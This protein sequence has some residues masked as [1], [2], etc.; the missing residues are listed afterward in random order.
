MGALIHLESVDSTNNFLKALALT[1]AAPGTAV[2]A[3]GQTAGRGR[4]E[5]GF[6]SPPG[7]GLYLS[8]LLC[9][10]A[11][12]E[13]LPQLTAWAGVAVCRALGGLG[14]D[15]GIK[16]VNDLALGGRKLGGIL[17]ELLPPRDGVC[18]VVVGVGLD[19]LQ[20]SFPAELAPIATSVL[21]E[22]GRHIP[23]PRAAEAVLRELLALET[24]FP[25]EKAGYLADY[26]RLCVTT[27]RQVSY[28]TL[29]ETRTG[30][31]RSV[32]EDFGLVVDGSGG[33]ETLRFGEVSVRPVP[34]REKG[35]SSD[36]NL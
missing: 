7:E 15:A 30:L 29:G 6:Y 26:R 3:D 12:V 31:A 13:A 17:T 16:W 35:M 19:L 11:P 20:E 22:T 5:H 18:P 21:R 25:R 2:L 10:A 8:V 9:P 27:G 4:G 23:V 34:E 32:D 1:G 14:V 28:L 24:A 33:R 36:E